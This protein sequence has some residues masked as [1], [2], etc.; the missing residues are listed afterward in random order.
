M[1][2][3]LKMRDDLQIE[4]QKRISD[5]EKRYKKTFKETTDMCKQQKTDLEEQDKKSGNFIF[6]GLV[7]Y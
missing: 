6:S 4:Y 3:E 7:F 2:R 1:K 5:I